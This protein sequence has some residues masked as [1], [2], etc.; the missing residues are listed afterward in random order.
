MAEQPQAAPSS[1]TPVERRV[2]TNQRELCWE[3]RDEYF[4]CLDKHGDDN[5]QACAA[6]HD[7]FNERCFASWVKHFEARRA[8]EAQKRRRLAQLDDAA[9]R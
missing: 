8:Y 2:F 5:K 9:K 4:A 1:S 7:V 6:L 3:A